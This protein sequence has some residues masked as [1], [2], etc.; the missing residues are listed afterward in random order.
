MGEPPDDQDSLLSLI[1][2]LVAFLLLVGN[3]WNVLGFLMFTCSLHFLNNL[4]NPE[5]IN[6]PEDF[7]VII[8][9][10]G[11]SGIC[12][13]KKLNELRITYTILE[14][15]PALGG[16]WWENTY[17]GA[18]CDV[19]SH[20]YSYSFYQ[21]PG[22]SRAYSHQQEILQ[23]LQN[24]ASRFGVYPHIKFEQ[25]IKLN[26][27][28]KT[29]NKWMIETENGDTYIC[30]VIVSG[31]GG[32]HVPKYPN[33][34]GMEEFMGEAFHTAR[35]KPSYDPTDK[36][37]AVI[38][39]GASA[40]QAVPTMAD[41]GVKNLTVFQRTPCWSPARLDFVYPEWIKIAFAIIPF[42]NCIYRWFFFWRNEFRYF[43]I[44]TRSRWITRQLS[45][46]VHKVVRKYI[47][48]TVKDPDLAKK[49]TPTYDMG[50]KRITP[51][52]T[53][54]QAFNRD[55]VNLVTE[56]IDKITKSG[57]QT[58]D[59]AHHEFDTIIFATGF[60]LDKS[61][62]PFEQI[63]LK[64]KMT[65]E[66]GDAPIA[67][68]GITHPH[69][70][71][72]FLL[73][74]PGTGLGHNS[75]IYMIECQANYARDGI[76]KMIKSGAKSM[77]LKPEVLKNYEEFVQENM[78]GKVF[79]DNTECVG[80]YRNARGVNWTLWPLDLVTYWWYT[81]S[82]DVNEYFVKY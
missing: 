15:S 37:V 50:C 41:M 53:Y 3:G 54:L 51:S 20:L 5:K 48:S 39:T 32:L 1:C 16:T 36:K 52:D 12:M 45:G 25:K 21:N 18:A 29:T 68:L 10:A 82:F 70:P 62:K 57:I 73:L 58:T 43:A 44:F 31:C 65:E 59:G 13:G 38:G 64:G 14:K 19:P 27:W 55:N 6:A 69:H 35:W 71:N 81:R 56:T 79:A 60:D 78:K 77:A 28:D 66:Y 76:V 42:T 4:R 22:W 46:V 49:L 26:T 74:G 47:K 33:F 63:G 61:A 8:L 34:E 2:S 7:H 40:V 11:V 23:Y 80:W 30:N 24:T 72:F 67:Y 9:G 17:P 75:I